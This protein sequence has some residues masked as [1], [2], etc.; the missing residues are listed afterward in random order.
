[1]VK[2]YT[3]D[4]VGPRVINITQDM[5]IYL[6]SIRGLSDTVSSVLGNL[7]LINAGLPANS[8]IEIDKNTVVNLDGRTFGPLDGITINVPFGG[9]INLLMESN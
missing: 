6:I 8:P 4:I 3:A 7:D 5:S 9:E 1:M 2:T